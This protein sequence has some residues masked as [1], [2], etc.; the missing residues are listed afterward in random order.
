MSSSISS[1]VDVSDI[2]QKYACKRIKPARVSAYADIDS[3]A[4]RLRVQF[5]SVLADPLVHK[6]ARHA[7]HK[8]L[9]LHLIMPGAKPPK[10]DLFSTAVGRVIRRAGKLYFPSKIILNGIPEEEA[11]KPASL[12]PPP[13]APTRKQRRASRRPPPF[14]QA[15][16]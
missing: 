13:P 15:Q 11:S 10:G 6:A 12:R 4:G 5:E 8:G 14:I 9:K 1:P 16:A 7:A 2:F 3:S